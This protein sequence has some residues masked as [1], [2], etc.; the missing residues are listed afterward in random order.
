VDD[1]GNGPKEQSPDE[2]EAEL[3]RVKAE[4][5]ELEAQVETLEAPKRHRLRRIFTPILV[6]LAVIVFTVSVPAVWS[7]RTVLNTDRYVATVGPLADDPA[8][9]QA[10]ATRLTDEVF[11]ALNVQEVISDTLA[12]IG[13]RATL[14]AGPLTNALHGFVQEQ[15]LK[16]VQS[17]AFETFWVDAN[18]FVHTQVLAVL[19]GE[20]ETV[21]L[22]EGK[23]LLNLVPLVNLAL[24]SI[25]SV[26][27]DLVGRDVT[28]PTFQP[29]EVASSEISKL[30]QA[31]GI[32]LPDDY[33][34]IPVYDSQDLEA[35]QKTLYTAKRLLILLLILIPVLVAAALL[36]STRRRRTLVQ[37]T[38]GGAIGL[39]VVRRVALIAR[40]GLFDQVNTQR[41]P[42]VRVLADT[43][44]DSLFRAT[45]ILLGIVLLTL[46]IALIT[47][48]Y[49]WAVT[50]RGWLRDGA[51]GIGSAVGGH[52][53]ADTDR[54]RWL[55]AH[56]DALMLAGGVVALLLLLLFNLS[57]LAFVIVTVLIAL[58]EIALVRLG[59]EPEGAETA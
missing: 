22:A 18:R 37:L 13:E 50:V 51:R 43:L 56:R 54:V 27:S 2:L 23:V 46:L 34:Q 55:R 32:D 58:Y 11:A 17:D 38:V 6:V 12:A 24:A 9:Q 10:I 39:V 19:R 49:P 16:V 4:R 52:P 57:W 3:E 30:E 8:V 44:M 36:V 7:A 25:E 28:L 33:G 15:V 26:S 41:H 5:D 40:D 35:L 14:L 48:P 53:A 29:G 20:S 45:G 47:G 21:S 1:K 31:L 42:A 59:H